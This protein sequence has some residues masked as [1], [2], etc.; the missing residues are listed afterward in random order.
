M[1]ATAFRLALNQGYG[2]AGDINLK[3]IFDNLFTSEQGK[4]YPAH[5]A[6]PQRLGRI[7]LAE[8]SS[9]THLP[10]TEILTSLPRD[11]VQHALTFPAYRPVLE[12]ALETEPQLR[13]IIHKIIT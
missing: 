12:K 10:M 4:G 3:L 2:W 7:K 13:E 11:V 1:P 6:E 5:R 9:I 8:V